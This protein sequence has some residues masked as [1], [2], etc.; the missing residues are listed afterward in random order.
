MCA[1][2]RTRGGYVVL[3]ALGV[4]GGGV[5][6]GGQFASFRF[7]SFFGRCSSFSG[8][9]VG[10]ELRGGPPVGRTELRC[11]NNGS[12]WLQ[13]VGTCVGMRWARS[14]FFCPIPARWAALLSTA[15][16]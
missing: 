16:G 1:G 8:V 15:N 2:D 12:L 11:L 6:G 10:E 3:Y 14:G 13:F 9:G 4:E 7:P 5:E